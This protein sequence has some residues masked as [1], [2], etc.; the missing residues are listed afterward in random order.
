MVFRLT[1]L[2]VAAAVCALAGCGGASSGA[3][4]PTPAPTPSATSL[5]TEL[6]LPTPTPAP[7]TLSAQSVTFDIFNPQ[8]Q[9]ITVTSA[10]FG[11]ALHA[12]PVDGTQVGATVSMTGT[13]SATVSLIPIAHGAGSPSGATSVTLQDAVGASASIAVTQRPCGRPDNLRPA[14]T[15]ISPQSGA[16]GV[17]PAVGRLYFAVT[18][19]VAPSPVLHVW[20]PYGTLEGSAL[21]AAT[22]PPGAASFTPGP[23]VTVMSATIG[24]LPTLAR[25]TTQIYDDPCQPAVVTGTFDT[26]NS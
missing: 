8:P 6:H 19:V 5:P 12:L 21:T 4:A 13:G 17:S 23:N 15:L 16:S 10:S 2:A 22:P 3:S 9:T 11:G 1:A 14:S 25:V 24:T 7:L 18:S 26:A 20:T